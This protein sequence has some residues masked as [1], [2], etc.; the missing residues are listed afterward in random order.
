MILKDKYITVI[1]I[2]KLNRILLNKKY[3]IKSHILKF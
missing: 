3:K 1:L 2:A